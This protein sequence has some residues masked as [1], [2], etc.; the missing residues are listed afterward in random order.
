MPEAE[1]MV[2]MCPAPC[3]SM[4][5][6]KARTVRNGASVFT[7][8]VRAISSSLACNRGL[9]STMP[10]LLMS[11]STAPC[12][13]SVRAAAASMD[14]RSTRLQA[15]TDAC[16][17]AAAISAATASRCAASTSHRISRPPFPAIFNAISRPM[18]LAAPVISTLRFL[19][20]VMRFSLRQSL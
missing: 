14:S 12:S 18:P 10:A 2:T 3:A 11:T 7:A 1:A 19:K 17:P 8:K 16:P 13:A 9:P 15:T 6:R 5:G 20:S 4:P